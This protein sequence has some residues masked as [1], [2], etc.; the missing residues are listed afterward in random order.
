MANPGQDSGAIKR[1]QRGHLEPETPYLP[2]W[3]ISADPARIA[4]ARSHP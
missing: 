3:A 2:R 4:E 1:K